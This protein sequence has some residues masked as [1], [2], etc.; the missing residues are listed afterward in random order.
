M[1]TASSPP[2]APSALPRV[3][4]WFATTALVVGTVIGSGVFKEPQSSAAALTDSSGQTYS[5]IAALVWVAGGLVVLLGA[6]AYAEIA[7]LF[8]RAGGNY[9][10]LY[11]GYGRLAGFLWGWVEFWIIRA[12]SLAALA[13]IFTESF[14]DV[15]VSYGLHVGFWSQRGI[16]VSVL[17]VL[18]AVNIRGVRWGS[19]LQ[20]VI[21][22]VKVASLLGIAILPWLLLGRTEPLPEAQLP[23]PA[24]R[25]PIWPDTWRMVSLGGLG[26]AMLAVQ[27]PYHGWMNIAPIA[28]EVK[29]PQRNIPIALLLGVA[30]IIALY[31]GASSAYYLAM[32]GAEMRE[33]KDTPVATVFAER[34][35]GPVG[36]V[37]L[38]AAIMCSVFGAL[39]G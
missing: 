16:T 33:F 18:A 11:E 1:N 21:T 30:I 7:A 17:V 10:F 36:G 37:L 5:G 3:L 23:D 8:P 13:T 15:L 24:N 9:V 38:S 31:L 26:A 32:T 35:L 25:E 20:V 22:A 2:P 6:L 28:G 34:L 27:W 19:G 39:N 12:G 14:R 4:G 29:H